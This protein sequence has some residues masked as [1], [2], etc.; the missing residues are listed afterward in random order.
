LVVFGAILFSSSPERWRSPMDL[1]G[2]CRSFS[3][4]QHW[5]L[6]HWCKQEIKSPCPFLCIYFQIHSSVLFLLSLFFFVIFA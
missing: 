3:R 5:A 4:E 2:L 6:Q 1:Q